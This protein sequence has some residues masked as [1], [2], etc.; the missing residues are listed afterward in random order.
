LRHGATHA[1]PVR[2]NKPITHIATYNRSNLPNSRIL[3]SHIISEKLLELVATNKK[4]KWVMNKMAAAVHIVVI[5]FLAILLTSCAQGAV[6]EATVEIA[7]LRVCV[8]DSDYLQQ[9][10][11]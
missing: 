6:D 5:V 7:E 3:Q 1:E 10:A 8:C 2:H 11:V 9:Q 4:G